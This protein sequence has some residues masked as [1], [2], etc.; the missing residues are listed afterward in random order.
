MKV[1]IKGL[2]HLD[3]T[4]LSTFVYNWEDGDLLAYGLDSCKEGMRAMVEELSQEGA[5][6][7]AVVKE[8]RA[9]DT[10]LR[11]MLASN[12]KHGLIVA[13]S[14]LYL[15]NHSYDLMPELETADYE[16]GSC[17]YARTVDLTFEE[18]VATGMDVEDTCR[19]NGIQPG[20]AAYVPTPGRMYFN[21]LV[22]DKL[23]DHIHPYIVTIG[24]WEQTGKL[25]DLER[26]LYEYALSEDLI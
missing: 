12:Y 26:V 9:V 3:A 2:Q 13:S 22:I 18:F 17:I 25:S 15:S 23:D 20:G 6:P 5:L 14:K 1:I 19:Y 7:E 8:L 11:A 16:D 21:S 10:L 24:S 4:K